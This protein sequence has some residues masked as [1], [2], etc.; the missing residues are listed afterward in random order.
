MNNV[1]KYLI[2]FVLS[3]IAA[4]A[5][6]GDFAF[7]GNTAPV[8]TETPEAS[9]GLNAVYVLNNTAGVKIAYTA[10]SNP[11]S[12]K[13]Y[14][15]GN[16]GGG[17]AQEVTS[18][19]SVEGTTSVLNAIDANKGY[20]I[21]EGTNRKY[22]WVVN[23]AD[24]YFSIDALAVSSESDC[25]TTIVMPVGFGPEMTYYTIN[26][27]RKVLD[28]EISLS[29]NTLEWNDETSSYQYVE[30]AK[31]FTALKESMLVDAPL[32]NTTFVVKGDKYLHFWGTEDSAE[33]DTYQ[34]QAVEVHAT[35]TRTNPEEGDTELGGSAPAD[36]CFEGFVTDAVIHKEWQ[37]AKD[38]EFVEILQRYDEET[39]NYTFNEA[40]TF[41]VRFMGA[42]DSGACESYSDIFT[43]SIGESDLRCPNA[44]SPEASEGINDVWRVKYKSIISFECHIFN[45]WG[46]EIFKFND[47]S[48]GWDGKYKGK[49]VGPG[50]Y[51][52]VIEAKGADGKKYKL[53]GDINIVG[54]NKNKNNTTPT[55]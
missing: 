50:V 33:S 40:G 19:I 24:F 21:E 18:G 31:S 25:S 23:Y 10:D 34:A 4:T 39:L 20:I 3:A 36:I 54:Y 52:Y 27:Q 48:Q 38:E 37:I 45:R 26:G 44:F 49:Y 7:L 2:S 41:Y 22:I 30:R 16:T 29:Y 42:N 55:E 13:W 12:V 35:A 14:V 5:S 6:A 9:T 11:A 8:F 32:C 17:Y 51:F 43:I 1:N 28:R 53:K 46:V 15:Y 47:P